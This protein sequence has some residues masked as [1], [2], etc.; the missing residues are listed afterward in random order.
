MSKC[1]AWLTASLIWIVGSTA[2]D[3]P[4]QARSIG[5]DLRTHVLVYNY[6]PISAQTLAE[7]KQLAAHIFQDAGVQVVWVDNILLQTPSSG[8]SLEQID[9]IIRVLPQP[10]ATLA[11]RTALGEALP[12]HQT[13]QGCM[14]SVF[15]NRVRNWVEVGEVSLEEVLAHA[16]AHELGH[17]LLGSN[18]HSARGL[19]RDTW[20][21]TN[22]YG[23]QRATCGSARRRP[24]SSGPTCSSDCSEG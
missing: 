10:R 2:L 22:C 12:C 9:L 21:Q 5:A 23:R 13:Q 24:E 19:M 6:A 7:A 11:S 16:I 18:S 20:G 14:A 8:V 15:Y 1:F 3:K 17:L 4:L